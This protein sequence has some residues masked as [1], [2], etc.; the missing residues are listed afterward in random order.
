MSGLCDSSKAEKAKLVQRA[1]RKQFSQSVVLD[2]EVISDENIW[3]GMGQFTY[4]HIGCVKKFRFHPNGK[5][6]KV[7]K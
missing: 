4:N 6:S 7:F 3:D 1:E 5:L 2:E